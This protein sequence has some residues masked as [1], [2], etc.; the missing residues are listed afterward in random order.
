MVI[1]DDLVTGLP[2]RVAGIELHE[3]AL[4][5][6]S[7]VETLA[8]ILRERR[9]DAVIH[10]AGRKQVFES[11]QR[12][13]WYYQQNVGSLATLLLA[14]ERA[15]VRRLVFSSSAS[16][17]GTTE[18]SAI[19][20]EDPTVPV[21]PYGHTKLI[22]E[23]MVA[24][25]GVAWGLRGI[26]LRY[27]NVAG[28]GSP[29]LGD[30]AVLN[31]VPMIFE[32]LDAGASPL[33]FGDGYPTADGSCVRDYI[34]V[35]DLADA[36]LATLDHL[37]QLPEGRHEAYN[38]GTGLGTSVLEMVDEIRR[39]SGLDFEAEIA[40]PRAGDPATVV[41]SA[42]KIRRDMGWVARLGIAE[43][44]ESAWAAHRSVRP[45]TAPSTRS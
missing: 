29:A 17:Y 2:E 15:D 10:F 39:V 28:A 21:N 8:D 11:V 19:V 3:C 6:P 16:V 9:I 1:V 22:G 37:P 7:A 43:I 20:E 32:R 44:I 30:R 45:G 24:D 31:L 5:E 42:A 38:V 12:P 4:E 36:H 14:M 35:V 13:A 34:H 40:P 18:G 26:S 33:V 25:A 23:Q 27:F 41:A